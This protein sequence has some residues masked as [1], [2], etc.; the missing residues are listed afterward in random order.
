M[1][2]LEGKCLNNSI[3][4]M[5]LFFHMEFNFLSHWSDLTVP[6]WSRLNE[7]TFLLKYWN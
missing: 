6:Y 3:G 4:V 7:S 5:E 2:L 1:F